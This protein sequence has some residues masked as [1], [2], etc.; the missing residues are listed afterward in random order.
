AERVD[1]IRSELEAHTAP[2]ENRPWLLV[3]TKLDVVNDRE[4]ILG[5]L[6]D[7]ASEHGVEWIAISAVT[8]EGVDR[9]LEM[10]FKMVEEVSQES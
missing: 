4:M 5:E 6:A 7:T 1:T 10:L 2:L 8:G 3:G 9:L